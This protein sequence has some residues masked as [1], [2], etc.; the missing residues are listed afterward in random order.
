MQSR[1][2]LREAQAAAD[3]LQVCARSGGWMGIRA[4]LL[5]TARKRGRATMCSCVCV[6]RALL[7]PYCLMISLSPHRRGMSSEMVQV[8]CM[9]WRCCPVCLSACLGWG[10]GGCL[11]RPAHAC[12]ATTLSLLWA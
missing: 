2:L 3:A 12:V 10:A 5:L 9:C 8:P 4:R 11:C 6:Q 1:Q 7:A